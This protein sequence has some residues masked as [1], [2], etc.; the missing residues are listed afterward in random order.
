MDVSLILSDKSHYILLTGHFERYSIFAEIGEHV[1]WKIAYLC[2]KV[3]FLRLIQI[4]QSATLSGRLT[5]LSHR[6]L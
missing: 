3:G 6:F 2:A 1:K 4:G 5:L